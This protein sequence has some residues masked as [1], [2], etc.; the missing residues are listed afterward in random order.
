MNYGKALEEV[1]KWREIVAKDIQSV[2]REKRVRQPL[3]ADK[4]HA[5]GIHRIVAISLVTHHSSAKTHSQA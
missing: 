3:T 2:P 4:T 5:A 1:W